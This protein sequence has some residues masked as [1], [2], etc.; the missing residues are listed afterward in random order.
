MPLVPTDPTNCRLRHCDDAHTMCS[1][2]ARAGATAALTAGAA[3]TR[4]RG[5]FW[6]HVRDPPC[7]ASTAAATGPPTATAAPTATWPGSKLCGCSF[8]NVQLSIRHRPVLWPGIDSPRLQLFKTATLGQARCP[9]HVQS[10][11]VK[12]FRTH[13]PMQQALKAIQLVLASWSENRQRLL[14]VSDGRLPVEGAPCLRSE[15]SAP[16]S[17]R[18]TPQKDLNPT[19]VKTGG[20]GWRG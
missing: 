8:G 10:L 5:R 3:A 11:A 2:A 19:T 9:T 17:T 4:R 6:R 16:K 12:A 14:A 1:R 20:W 15:T 18:P 7:P 13:A